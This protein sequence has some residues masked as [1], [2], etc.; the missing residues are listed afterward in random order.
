[1]FDEI[2]QNIHTY[3]HTYTQEELAAEQQRMFDEIRQKLGAH[4]QQNVMVDDVTEK[5]RSPDNDANLSQVCM[6]M[7]MCMYMCMCVCMYIYIYIYIYIIGH[8]VCT[9]E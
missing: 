1:V 7:C 2:P 3:I 4:L 8:I 6:C 9:S 5:Y